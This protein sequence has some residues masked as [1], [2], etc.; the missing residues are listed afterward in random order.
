MPVQHPGVDGTRVSVV[1]NGIPGAEDQLLQIRQRNEILDERSP[2]LGP[3]PETNGLHLGEA[4]HGLG[5]PPS[6]GLDAGYERGRHGPETGEQD[7]E[8]ALGGSNIRTLRH[9]ISSLNCAHESPRGHRARR[10]PEHP[11][12]AFP[13]KAGRETYWA[14]MIRLSAPSSIPWAMVPFTFC[15]TLSKLAC[16]A[17]SRW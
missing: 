17:T 15:R 14:R 2:L 10:G 5:D 4:A 9:W 6:E 1:G 3:L 7:A 16:A 13:M 12:P 11:R 8:L